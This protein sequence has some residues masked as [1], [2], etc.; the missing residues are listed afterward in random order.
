M[1][2]S[3]IVPVDGSLTSWRAVDVAIALAKRCD[4]T[5]RIVEVVFDP[6]DRAS[7]LDRLNEELGQRD[8]GG[9]DVTVGVE[10]TAESVPAQIESLI[11]LD[12]GAT[13]VMA[14]HGRGRSA[15]LV[16][17]VAEDVLT[18]TFG[19]IMIV[20]PNAVISDFSG[21]VVVSV[22]GSEESEAALPLAAAWAIELRA[23]TWIVHVSS[24]GL[25]PTDDVYD[26]AYTARLARELGKRSGHVMQYDE[27][28]DRHPAV[29]VPEYADQL[30]ASLIVASSHGRSGWSRFTMGR[31]TSGFVRHATCPVLV[32]RLPRPVAE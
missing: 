30:G 11:D 10:V 32:I 17:S 21:A 16:G 14:S 12:P 1:V 31:V 8:L 22:D 24:P 28:H 5:V 13:I 15:A 25:M 6:A 27:L 26:T 19:P 20:G 7:T 9:V 2:Q 4:A 29:A 3:L 18:R 23:E